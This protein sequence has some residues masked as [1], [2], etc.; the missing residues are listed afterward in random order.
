MA[1]SRPWT[2][3]A[4][5][6]IVAPAEGELQRRVQIGDASVATDQD[7]ALGLLDLPQNDVNFAR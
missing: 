7:A 1:F 5:K 2:R 3:K 6:V 4:V